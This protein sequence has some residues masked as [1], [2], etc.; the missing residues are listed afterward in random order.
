MEKAITNKKI[1]EEYRKRFPDYF[2]H[3]A[4]QKN[5]KIKNAQA[6]YNKNVK[7]QKDIKF[8]S[9]INKT[10]TEVGRTGSGM[11]GVLFSP[12]IAGVKGV[13]AVKTRLSKKKL[14]TAIKEKEAL[15]KLIK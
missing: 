10:D 5:K 14:R 8:F 11:L 3:Q 6:L 15:W 9:G 4:R 1:Q 7:K 13:Q 2:I 12:I